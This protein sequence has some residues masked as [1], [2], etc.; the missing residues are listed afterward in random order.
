MMKLT[1]GID[2]G[3]T[4]AKF[5]AV[6]EDG[7][8]YFKGAIPISDKESFDGFVDHLVNEINQGLSGLNF[9]YDI[10][11]VGV[12]AP[13]GNYYSGNIEHAVNLPWSGNL[14]IV[15]K[16]ADA[17]KVPVRLTNDAN[18]AALGEMIFGGAKGMRNFAMITLGTGLGS[19]FVAN[20]ELI[21]GQHGFA[22]ELGHVTIN[23]REGRHC[24]CGRKGCLETYVSATG[25][26]R[27]IYKLLADSLQESELRDTSF[28][29]LNTKMITE[30]AARKDEI[31][32]EAFAYTGKILGSKLA[33]IVNILNPEAIFLFGGLS[34][35]GDFIF[36]PT[37][38]YLNEQLM[39]IYKSKTQLLPS[40]LPN[41]TAP[42]LGASSLIW[43]DIKQ[44]SEAV[45]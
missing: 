19:G 17:F 32:L 11:G 37:N 12:G 35:A 4:S 10:V 39:N 21:L 38:K 30:A 23:H 43:N 40:K 24:N 41:Q 34:L 15:K 2:I 29:A 31:A 13:H 22:G 1:I 44:R 18:A 9:D 7:I 20:G 33:D 45:V 16:L 42:I 27:T 25:M 3:G 36:E 28:N 5:G 14:P 6:N 26:K 8:V